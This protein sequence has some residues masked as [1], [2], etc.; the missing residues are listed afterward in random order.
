[1]IEIRDIHKRLGDFSLRGVSVAIQEREYFVILGP[2]GAGK[3]V[4]LECIAG[5][6]PVDHGQ[7][8]INGVDVTDFPPER[9]R[10]SYVPQDYVLFPH[11]S[12]YENIAFS[13]RLLR[14]PADRIEAR[15]TELTDLLRISHLLHRAPR[16]LSGGEQ[17]RTALARA[18]APQPTALLLDEPL[19]ALDETTRIAVGEEL[20]TLPERFGTT[21]VHVCHDFEEALRLATRIGIIYQGLL[22]QVGTPEEVFTRPNCRFVAEF[23]RVRNLLPVEQWE[24]T[25]H[26]VLCQ[27]AGGPRLLAAEA[28]AWNGPV[29]ATIRPENVVIKPGSQGDA[30]SFSATV[31]DIEVIGGAADVVLGVGELRLHALMTRQSIGQAA[32]QV[33][34]QVAASIAPAD[35]HLAPDSFLP[36]ELQASE[37]QQTG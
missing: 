32:L 19:S 7:V 18:L 3:T 30:S 34:S 8:F 20:K 26:G 35:V 33:G 1:M 10:I 16:T 4:L 2:T 37:E 5:L 29:I 36:P 11:L 12:V 24:K 13:L 9:R 27:I 22:V 6:H 21:L 14:W 15:V 28:P 17:Q 23:T 31:T 25:A